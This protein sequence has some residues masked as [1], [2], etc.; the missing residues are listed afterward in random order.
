MAH[1]LAAKSRIKQTFLL[2]MNYMLSVRDHCIR[3]FRGSFCTLSEQMKRGRVIHAA[4]R[5]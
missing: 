2:S 3:E 1:I 4:P 5:T